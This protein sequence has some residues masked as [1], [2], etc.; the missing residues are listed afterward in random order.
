MAIIQHGIFDEADDLVMYQS[1]GRWVRIPKW[2]VIGARRG[3]FRAILAEYGIEQ[4]THHWQERFALRNLQDEARAIMRFYRRGGDRHYFNVLGDM[5]R[6][7]LWQEQRILLEHPHLKGQAFYELLAR[8]MGRDYRPYSV[9]GL[10]EEARD[11]L[12]IDF[13]RREFRTLKKLCKVLYAVDGSEALNQV[14]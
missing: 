9:K 11:M 13:R 5:H 7:V 2:A 8:R 12:V 4:F 1:G 10:L 14:A 6:E 3:G